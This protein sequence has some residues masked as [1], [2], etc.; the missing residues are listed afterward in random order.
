[1]Q[2]PATSICIR[3]EAF[4]SGFYRD[5]IDENYLYH[6]LQHAADVVEAVRRLGQQ[7]CLSESELEILELAAWLHDTGFRYGAE[8][9]EENSAHI[10]RDFLHREEYPVEAIAQV[11]G[12]ILATKRFAAPQN[13]LQQIIRDA[14]YSHLGSE[15]YWD[16]SS[17]I[18]QELLMTRHNFMPEE[19]WVEFELDFMLGHSFHTEVAQQLLEAT[20]QINIKQLRKYQQRIQ[21]G[22]DEGLLKKKK[23]KKHANGTI[24]DLELGRG[25]ETM[26]R[27]TYRTHINLSAI[28]DNKANIMLGINAIIISIAISSLVPKFTSDPRLILPTMVL[29]S[30]CLATL[31]FAILA[32][33]PNITHGNFSKQD[34]TDKKANLLFFGNFYNMPIEDFHWGMMEMI[35]DND[36]LYSSMTRDLYFLGKVLAQ[37]YRLLRIGYSVFMFGMILT[38][39]AFGAALAF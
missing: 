14:D 3:T 28:A 34:I 9:H 30:V 6:N 5:F 26:F 15:L 2:Q 17:R 33:R 21:P 13:L 18:R 11:E 4:V 37:K 1:M 31:V 23:K 25:V 8:N 12:L 27:T 29:L 16:R 22:Y 32:T 7:Y 38:V 36:F 35:R 10:A 20:K 39:L 24:S 19:E